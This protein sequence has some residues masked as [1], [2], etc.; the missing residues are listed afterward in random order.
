MEVHC[1]SDHRG[2]Q[3]KHGIIEYLT[4]LG[5]ACVDHGCD[6]PERVD[7]PDFARAVA[8]AIAGCERESLGILVCGSG[9]GIAIPA[10]KMSG[11]RCVVAWCEHVAEYG[12]RH[13]HANVLAFS[14][15]LQTLTSVKR[16]LDAW[17]AAVPEG[18]RHAER[19]Q[20]ID[21][22]D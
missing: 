13:N 12:R 14:G 16:C 21:A 9:V 5:H 11:I 18:G 1:G 10:N 17:L 2:L 22:M 3:L 20:M 4:E 8:T 6:S 19:V 15:D 7:Y